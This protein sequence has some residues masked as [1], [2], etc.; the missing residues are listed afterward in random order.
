MQCR[1][2]ILYASRSTNRV[3]RDYSTEVLRMGALGGM[4]KKGAGSLSG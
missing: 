4:A 3:L 1:T 2:A